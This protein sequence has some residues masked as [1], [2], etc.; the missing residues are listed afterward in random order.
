MNTHL[1]T[2]SPGKV[3]TFALGADGKMPKH[4][5]REAKPIVKD[6]EYNPDH[7][8]LC[9]KLY[10]SNC[11]FCHGVPAVNNGGNIPNLGYSE[12]E[13]IEN[14]EM[15]TLTDMRLSLSMP[16]FTGTLTKEDVKKIQAFIQNT[17]EAAQN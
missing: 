1:E 4:Q 17:A 3:Y 2:S 10:I 7:V 13:V 11:V 6:V 5:K 15:F 8:G 14:L 16:N 12:K 9:A